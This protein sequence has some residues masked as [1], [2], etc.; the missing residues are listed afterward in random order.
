MKFCT[1]TQPTLDNSKSLNRN[2]QFI[3]GDGMVPAILHRMLDN[4]KLKVIISVYYGQFSNKTQRGERPFSIK[5]KIF[6][7]KTALCSVLMS[8][9]LQL[10]QCAVD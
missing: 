6:K 4:L 8:A 5:F 3:R 10:R 9:P 1:V 7:S 2:F